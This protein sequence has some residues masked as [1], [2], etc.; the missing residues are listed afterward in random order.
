M[1]STGFPKNGILLPYQKYAFE[2]LNAHKYSVLLWS[3]QT[4]KSFLIS[5]W[6]V[7]R[8]LELKNHT[9]LIISP[10]ERQSKN[11]IDKVKTHVQA[12]KIAGA[13][14]NEKMFDDLKI[15]QLEVVLPNG[16]RIIGLPAN[17]DGV[18]GFS[19]DVILEEAAFFKDGRAVLQAIFPTITRKKEY[20][21]IAISTPRGKNDIFYHLWNIA[22]EDPFY[23]RMKLTIFDAA[24]Q[25][26][27][28]DIEALRRG[29]P[30]EDTWKTEYL[31]EF[32][33]ENETLLSYELIQ[34]CESDCKISDVREL[35]GD[36]FLGIDVGRRKDLTV[37]SIVEMLGEIL[38]LRHLEILK[39]VP[40]EE[41][42]NI[43]DHYAHYARRLAIDE[44]GIGMMLAE[45]LQKRWGEMKV[46]PVYFTQR[47]KEELASRLK[48]VFEDRKIRI[49]PERDLRE[50]LHS[51][52]KEI[53]PSGNIKLSADSTDL[54]HADRFWALALA[55]KA[56]GVDDNSVYVTPVFGNSKLSRGEKRWD[57]YRIF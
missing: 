48:S 16:S 26:L 5:L 46:L 2:K 1:N 49:F 35:K 55:V 37:I 10:T 57:S 18:R 51:I 9:I 3:R 53:T 31:C 32:A 34:S 43:I 6:A 7:L 25:G 4:G 14:V 40:F 52:K 28:V 30:D 13:Q 54:G 22:G 19:G 45:Q 21:L 24:C 47:T 27:D 50:D 42:F 38:Y 20:K 41:Q 33:D 36:I 44:T 56:S 23:F 29:C 39:K 8:A 17:P 12:F 11:L 15:N